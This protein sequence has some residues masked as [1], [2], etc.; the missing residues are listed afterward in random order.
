MRRHYASLSDEALIALDLAELIETAQRLYDEELA[1]RGLTP[2]Q[3]PESFAGPDDGATSLDQPGQVED[4]GG[5]LAVD[6]GPPPDWLEDAACACAFAMDAGTLY[7]SDAAKARAVLRAAGIPCHITVNEMDPPANVDP[8]PRYEYCVMVPGA[9]NLHATS[10]LDREIFNSK[11][12]A[13]WR[14]HLEAL[15]DEELCA[16]N[17][18]TFCAGLLDRVTRLRRAFNDESARRRPKLRSAGDS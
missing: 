15:S 5:E 10:V 4:A 3:E 1:G 13:D 8:R 17:P 6:A 14:T 11:Q 7:G 9:L 2:R 16:L 18:E 12:E